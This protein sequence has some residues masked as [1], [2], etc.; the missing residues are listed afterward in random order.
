M[1]MRKASVLP[2]P[3][4]A[5]AITSALGSRQSGSVSACTWRGR[6]QV[7]FRGIPCVCS[8]GACTF[9]QCVYPMALEMALLLSSLIGSASKGTFVS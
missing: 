4:L 7:E 1:G 9:V 2:V 3:V 6:D 5:L 8:D